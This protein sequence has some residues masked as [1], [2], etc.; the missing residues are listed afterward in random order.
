MLTVATV[1]G[2]EG[3]LD[4]ALR[5]AKEKSGVKFGCFFEGKPFRGAK[6]EVCFCF[7]FRGGREAKGNLEDLGSFDGKIGGEAL[8]CFEGKIRGKP[9]GKPEKEAKGNPE[10]FFLGGKIRGKPKI[11]P[12][13]VGAGVLI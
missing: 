8:G 2:T 9:K 1:H 6:S 11:E 13:N 3:R 10:G 5:V 12:E 7:C 4:D